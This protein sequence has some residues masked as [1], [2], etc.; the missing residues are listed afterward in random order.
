MLRYNQTEKNTRKGTHTAMDTTPKRGRPKKPREH[1]DN[2]VLEKLFYVLAERSKQDMFKQQLAG[3]HGNRQATAYA[4]RV[5]LDS[6]PK[7]R[8]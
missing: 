6:L 3:E 1:I 4:S 2:T 8:V 7:V 5:I